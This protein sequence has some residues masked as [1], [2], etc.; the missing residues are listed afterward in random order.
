MEVVLGGVA[1]MVTGVIGSFV[2]AIVQ[3]TGKRLRN[4]RAL[5]RGEPPHKD[6]IYTPFWVLFGILGLIAGLSWTWRLDGTWVTG[7][8]AGCGF[9][10]LAMVI[11]LG[12]GLSQLR[13]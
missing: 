6:L 9:P 11:F 1:G 2:A 5:R 3:L 10:A 13:R 12:W 4:S 8:V 7:A